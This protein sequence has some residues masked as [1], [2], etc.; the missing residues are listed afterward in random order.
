[1]ISQYRSNGY[2]PS[3]LAPHSH[4]MQHAPLNFPGK[5]PS[6]VEDLYYDDYPEAKDD[7]IKAIHRGRSPS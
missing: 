5:E 4:F 1:M 2:A 7:F 3:P 6:M